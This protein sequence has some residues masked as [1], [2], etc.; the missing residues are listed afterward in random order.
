MSD[1]LAELS[2]AGVAIWLDDISRERLRTG[3]LE[4][5]VRDK[6]VV[7]VTSNPTI[8]QKAL[9]EGD[10][11]DEQIRD[12]ALRGLDVGEAVRSITAYDVRWGCDVLRDVH[13]RTDGVDG[14][15]SLEVDPRIAHD[16]ARTVAEAK[17]LWWLVDRPNLFIKIPATVEGL[18][19]ITETLA[20]GISVNVTLIFSLDRYE[21]VMDAFLAGLEQARANGHDLTRIG[22]V[23]SFFV[24]RN[25]T[26][27]D[28][29]VDKI[30]TEEAKAL[31]GSAAIANARLAYQRYERVFGGDR[32]K[33]LAEAGAHPQRPLWASTGV[34]DPAYDDTRYV[35][36]LV[37]PGVV[38]TMPEATLNAVAD[39]GQIRGDTIRDRY[40][41]AQQV[42]DR[43]AAL[44]IE[45]QDVVQTLEDE[46]V[47]KFEDS[48]NELIDQV[49]ASL[50]GAGAEVGPDG[51]TRPA[52][53]GPAAADRPET[54]R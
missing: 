45:Y 4:H 52:G 8:F 44:G 26:E 41:E 1:P 50:E 12:L 29:R 46:G 40:A 42:L 24:S 47:R 43:L 21:Q 14:R 35:V 11:Y 2:A 54:A 33:A 19:A 48:W 23:A 5:L 28:K 34:K 15:V 38:N 25:D 13:D 27:T 7:G 9:S 51:A 37:A 10:A 36:E 49:T 6:H 17:A 39:H 18:P 20:A 22:S 32:W 16:T 3:N 53:A 31:R 30:G